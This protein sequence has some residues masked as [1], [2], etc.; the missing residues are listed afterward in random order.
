MS[1]LDL[2]KQLLAKCDAI[3]KK[4]QALQAQITS[5]WEEESEEEDE[6]ESEDEEEKYD[7]STQR[8]HAKFGIRKA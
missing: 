2:I 1:E 8:N 3:E 5:L 6:T 4:I 7:F